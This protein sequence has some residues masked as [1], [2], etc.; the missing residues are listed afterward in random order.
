M[1]R[2]LKHQ[3]LYAREYREKNRDRIK[4]YGKLYR[5]LHPEVGKRSK[6]LYELRHKEERYKKHLEW[7]K[8]NPEKR[9]KYYAKFL[10]SHREYVKQYRR[11]YSKRLIR[12]QALKLYRLKNKDKTTSHYL[13]NQALKHGIIKRKNECEK[14]NKK[15]RL[16]MHH[17]DYKK[18]LEVIFLC[19]RCHYHAHRL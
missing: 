4:E 8:K 14:C 19:C 13:A 3:K 5:E 18:P 17:Q 6:R 1:A 10:E 9:R 15:T 2:D 11:K 16:E 12:K 7:L